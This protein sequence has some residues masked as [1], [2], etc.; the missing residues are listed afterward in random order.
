MVD[1]IYAHVTNNGTVKVTLPYLLSTSCEMVINDFPFD[2]KHC[3][4]DFS[5]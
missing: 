5:R 4:L 2:E 3:L 1:I